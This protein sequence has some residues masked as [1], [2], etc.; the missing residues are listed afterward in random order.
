MS[1]LTLCETLVLTDIAHG[2]SKEEIANKHHWSA[3]T[4][5]AFT[6]NVFNKLGVSKAPHAVYEAMKRGYLT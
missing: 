4:V 2:M 3:H 6:T 1:V 5:K